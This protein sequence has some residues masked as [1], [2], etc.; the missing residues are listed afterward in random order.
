LVAESVDV[1]KDLLLDSGFTCDGGVSL[2][3]AKIDGSIAANDCRLRAPDGQALDLERASVKLNI[4][5]SSAAIEGSLNVRGLT[6]SGDLA[7]WDATIGWQH[8]RRDEWLAISG[9]SLTVGGDLLLSDV[10]LYGTVDLTSSLISGT[11]RAIVVRF[12][13][14]GDGRAVSLVAS[15]VSG[16][17][18]IF[19]VRIDGSFDLS[20]AV[21]KRQIMVSTATFRAPSGSA[22]I[23]D[24]LRVE[25]LFTMTPN[26]SVR[27]TVALSA[28]TVTGS[29]N[30]NGVR[31]EKGLASEDALAAENLQV[32]AFL[33]L[34]KAHV[35]GVLDISGVKATGKV[36]LSDV[37][38]VATGATGVRAAHLSVDGDL[39]L[40]RAR[41]GACVDLYHAK[42]DGSIEADNVRIVSRW[43]PALRVPYCEIEGDINLSGLI[44]GETRALLSFV[45]AESRTR[46]SIVADRLRV[47]G[48]M[49][50]IDSTVQGGLS[51]MGGHIQGTCN[52]NGSAFANKYGKSLYLEATKIDEHLLL[53]RARARGTV[54]LYRAEVKGSVNFSD[55]SL[56]PNINDDVTVN[57]SGMT[58]AGELRFQP[59]PRTGEDRL[60]G[61]VKW[62]DASI[63]VLNDSTQS[64]PAPGALNIEGLTYKS[65]AADAPSSYSERIR[66]LRLQPHHEFAAQPYEHLVSVFRSHGRD[67]DARNT[68][69][70]KN[71]DWRSY[72]NPDALGRLRN[73]LSGIMIGHGYKPQRA[74]WGLGV[75]LVYS[76]IVFSI[77]ARA[78][79]FVPTQQP[80]RLAV[81]SAAINPNGSGG[82]PQSLPRPSPAHC[83][84]R[85]PCFFPV[86][87]AFETVVPL[88][89]LRQAERWQPNRA[90]PLGWLYQISAWVGTAGGWI[91]ST[92]GL[93]AVTG[94]ARRA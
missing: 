89:N 5:L 49:R 69:I 12:R 82:T 7:I 27:G 41:I 47:R 76:A 6:V 4:V 23:G 35:R 51:L 14:N 93:A 65:F 21:I 83:T 44:A 11:L 88:V 3:Q 74:L 25:G 79:G 26:V 13:S 45:P 17:L 36:N 58:I 8:K 91:L 19:R 50:I 87:Y 66:W 63:G 56:G 28:A 31:L 84:E 61:Q 1:Q 48:S 2:R 73:R 15:E 80:Q 20:S 22:I 81:E 9:G 86:A 39:V 24:G 42:I 53:R 72:G 55:A 71:S 40:E 78:N 57:G 30:W 34:S 68:A 94:L 46:A 18:D 92:I 29:I 75:L 77:G 60:R 90:A 10:R 64:W 59:V 85:Y 62:Q 37:R 16:G 54:Y 52:L 67:V 70:A 32:G 33:D 38:V 43:A